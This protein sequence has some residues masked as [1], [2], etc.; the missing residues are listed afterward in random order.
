MIHG[1]ETLVISLIG[2]KNIIVNFH[3]KTIIQRRLFIYFHIPKFG[4][5]WDVTS[6]FWQT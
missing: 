6:W 2:L 4:N 1:F 3:S 5:F